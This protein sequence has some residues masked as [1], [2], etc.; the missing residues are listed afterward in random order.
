MLLFLPISFIPGYGVHW[1]RQLSGAY[2]VHWGRHSCLSIP[3]SWCACRIYIN[4]FEFLMKFK[5]KGDG[6]LLSTHCSRVDWLLAVYVGMVG[7]SQVRVGFVA[8]VTTALMPIIGWSRYLLGDILLQRAFHKDRPRILDNINNFHKSKVERV[9]FLAPEGTIADPGIDE[10]YVKACEQFMISD[11]RKP[12]THLLTPRYKGMS[13]FVLHSPNNVASCAMTFVTGH[14]EVDEKTGAMI[15][16]VKHS[17]SMSNPDRMIPDLH[18]IFR[19]GMAAFVNIHTL[20]LYNEGSDEIDEAGAKK[21]REQLIQDQIL[22]DGWM[23]TFEETGKFPGIKSASDWTLFPALHFRMNATLIVH[24]LV[25]IKTSAWLFSCSDMKVVHAIIGIILL[26]FAIH[27]G[28]HKI[29]QWTTDGRS[30]ESLVG[31]TAIKAFLNVVFK[32]SMNQGG[33]PKEEEQKKTK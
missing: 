32:R 17:L 16:G 24:T 26:A 12:L 2:D 4:D 13:A 27:G 29:G 31:E 11:G 8:E 14:P 22:K 28:S 3:F 1:Y 6:L 5:E 25:T 33:K 18:T 21:I 9:L 10:E 15:G 7:R 20:K 19:G 23:R 30:R